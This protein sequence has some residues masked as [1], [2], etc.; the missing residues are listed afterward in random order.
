MRFLVV[1]T[2][3]GSSNRWLRWAVGGPFAAHPK[4]LGASASACHAQVV[5][6]SEREADRILGLL[7]DRAPEAAPL[8]P[9]SATAPPSA[10]P[11]LLHLCFTRLWHRAL[12]DGGPPQM[13]HGPFV[14]TCMRRRTMATLQLANGETAYDAHAR[15]ALRS[16]LTSGQACKG[17]RIMVHIRGRACFYVMSDLDDVCHAL[18]MI[19]G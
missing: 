16:M 4:V 9:F 19:D 12:P 17:A 10:R 13:P 3:S 18:R 7:W 11:T 1:A 5:L 8:P 6:L 15:E 2:I 14:E